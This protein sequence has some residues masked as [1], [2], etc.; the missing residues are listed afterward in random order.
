MRN[1][2]RSSRLTWWAR[3]VRTDPAVPCRRTHPAT[4]TAPGVVGE[5]EKARAGLTLIY[6]R[7]PADVLVARLKGADNSGRPPLTGP[8]A[9]IFK[10]MDAVLAQRDALYQRISHHVLETG[11]LTAERVA[12]GVIELCKAS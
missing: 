1:S 11:G 7:A 3:V 9:D 5:L 4:P 2:A 10:E 6:L 8:G 12:D